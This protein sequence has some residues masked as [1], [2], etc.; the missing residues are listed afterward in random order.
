[1]RPVPGAGPAI[2]CYE[3]AG[4][5]DDKSRRYEQH[6]VRPEDGDPPAELPEA[7]C[8]YRAGLDKGRNGDKREDEGQE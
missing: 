2:P 8:R 7:S 4:N 5:Q 1:M 6:M 3:H